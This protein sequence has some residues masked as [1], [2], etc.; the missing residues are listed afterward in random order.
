MLERPKLRRDELLLPKDF[1]SDSTFQ[2]L[3]GGLCPIFTAEKAK[4]ISYS[5]LNS[6]AASVGEVLRVTSP[7]G[8]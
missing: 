2:P 6:L 7:E 1:S 3:L 8:A 4:E 5:S